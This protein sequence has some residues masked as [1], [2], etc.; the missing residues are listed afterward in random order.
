MRLRPRRLHKQLT[1]PACGVVLADAELSS[2][3]GR[4]EL[5]STEGHVLQPTGVGLQIRATEQQLAE[6]G[7]LA[8]SEQARARLEF[9]RRNVGELVYDLRCRSDHSTL[10]TMPQLVQAIRRTPGQWVS[11][12]S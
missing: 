2:W 7:S 1:C 8:E 9:L 5:T 4:L 10:R 12:G 6:A 3:A 11:L